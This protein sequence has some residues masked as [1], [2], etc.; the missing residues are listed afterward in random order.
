MNKKLNVN[1]TFIMFVLYILFIFISD[2]FC[3]LLNKNFSIFAYLLS[4]FICL[5]VIVFS[6]K[7]IKITFNFSKYDVFFMVFLFIIVKARVVI[8][9]SSFDTLNYHLYIQERLFSNNVSYNFFPGR[10]INT[11]SFPLGDRLHYLVRIVLGY[12]LGNI[13][14]V[15][16]VIAVY[17]QIKILLSKVIKNDLLIVFLAS[18]VLITEQI[19]MNMITYYVDLLSIPLFLGIIIILVE[20]KKVDN[21]INWFV[22]LLSGIVVSLKVSNA[23]LLIPLAVLYLYKYR[24][25]MNIYTFVI[26]IPIFVLP[27]CI[28]IINNYIQTGNPV[29]PFYNS[30]FKSPY[31]PSE[32]WTESFYGPKTFLERLFWPVYIYYYPRRSFDTDFYYGRIS[33]GY[34]ISIICLISFFIKN[35]FDFKKIKFDL[36]EK[37]S[38]L[39]IVYCLLW[40]NFMMGYIRYALI[41]EIISGIVTLLFVYKYLRNKNVILFIF[42]IFGVVGV[43]NSTY[44]SIGNILKDAT[45]LSWRYPKELD[46]ATY[47][48]NKHLLL[49]RKRSY[50][51][52]LKNVDC[53]G[54]VDYNSGYAAMMSD[55]MKILNLNE[56][57]NNDYGKKEFEKVYASCKNVYTISTSPTLS[58]TEDYLVKSGYKRVG[59]NLVIKSEF[60]NNNY[61]LIIFEIEK[62]S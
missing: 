62:E 35:G 8:P 4:G 11:F 51:E 14:N 18:L 61:D 46:D 38:L 30:I 32:N 5:L 17:Y 27:F 56:G 29:F 41:L 57:Y 47:L 10:W 52:F 53:F 55:D 31:L 48:N 43:F 60:V 7:K 50:D 26:G 39:N 16:C 21:Y 13:L 15:Y 40:S 49:N 59:D 2:I 1:F 19:L 45:E 9:D 20:N 58:R 37:M 33:Y 12:R 44:N 24:K 28:Y 3:F 23:F 25:N 36:L 34:I 22:L 54:I 42:C 6:R